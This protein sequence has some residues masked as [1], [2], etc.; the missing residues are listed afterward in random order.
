MIATAEVFCGLNDFV[1]SAP[2]A[3]E[4]PPKEEPKPTGKYI[5]PSQRGAAAAG[6][7][8]STPS[9]PTLP[10]HIRNRKKVAPNIKSEEDFP[11][12]SGQPAQIQPDR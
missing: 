6:G 2:P 1:S 11:T 9:G 10:T 5:P 8:A 3:V 7:G 4:E 12:L